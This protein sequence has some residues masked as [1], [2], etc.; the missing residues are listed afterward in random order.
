MNK[1]WGL[2]LIGISVFH[3]ELGCPADPFTPERQ[4][5]LAERYPSQDITASVWDATSGCVFSLNPG[6]RQR[7]ASVF[8]VMVMA[9]AL[10]EAQTDGRS[11]TLQEQDLIEPMISI[12]ANNPVR[13]LW[14]LFGGAP[15]YAEQGSNFGLLDTAVVGDSELGWG[16]T[17]TT[18]SDQVDL[19]R[20]LLF[21]DYGDLH[22]AA[23]VQAWGFMTNIAQAQRW[24]VGTNAPIGS[25][26]AQKNGFAGSVA[27]SVGGVLRADGSGY[28]LAI[29]SSGWSIWPDGVEVV[30]MISGWIHESF[31]PSPDRPDPAPDRWSGVRL[32]NM[33]AFG[34]PGLSGWVD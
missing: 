30:D 4:M 3:A 22:E 34:A 31:G 6:N 27:N 21:R 28:A 1:A 5:L 33:A 20:Q 8:K 9:G 14:R 7:T 16:G 32:N 10:L 23:R 2:L 13:E 11:L 29:L 25:L 17:L 24:G 19:L 12:S 26:V 18:A 15:W